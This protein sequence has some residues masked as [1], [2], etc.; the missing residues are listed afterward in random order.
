MIKF[1][2]YILIFLGQPLTLTPTNTHVEFF[3]DSTWHTVH[4]K[5]PDVAGSIQLER[6]G[7]ISSARA[8]VHFRVNAFDTENSSRDE[9]MR[10]VLAAEQFPEV[11]FKEGILAGKCDLTGLMLAQECEDVLSGKLMIRGHEETV[12]FPVQMKREQNEIRFSATTDVDWTRYGV[13]DP[14]IIIAKLDHIAHIHLIV[15]VPLQ[16]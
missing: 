10:E 7:E 5:V 6:P 1:L 15:T 9:R 13:E 4:G 12:S 14:S 16:S 11:V 3:V 2:G 8:E